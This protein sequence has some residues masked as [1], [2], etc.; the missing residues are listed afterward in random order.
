MKNSTSPNSRKHVNKTEWVDKTDARRKTQS[1]LAYRVYTV[2]H[3]VHIWTPML[4][5]LNGCSGQ[6]LLL[7]LFFF[8][9][10]YLWFVKTPQV[11][12]WF[13]YVLSVRNQLVLGMSHSVSVF[14]SCLMTS[15]QFLSRQMFTCSSGVTD[16]P[17]KWCHVLMDTNR[18]AALF[19]CLSA[20]NFSCHVRLFHWE[21]IKQI[22]CF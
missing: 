17:L 20:F 12:N 5:F 19:L 21:H 2:R 6:A 14:P 8:A 16:I 22:C 10:L 3:L 11:Q 15:H 4:K 9:V 18:N 1:C 13:C 7:S